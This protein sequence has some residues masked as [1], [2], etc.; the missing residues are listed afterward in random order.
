[1]AGSNLTLIKVCSKA[2]CHNYIDLT[3]LI[4]LNSRPLFFTLIKK[5]CRG[6]DF[7]LNNQTVALTCV[8]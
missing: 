2:K 7:N 3:K 5:L 8:E 1:M 6:N 4:Y